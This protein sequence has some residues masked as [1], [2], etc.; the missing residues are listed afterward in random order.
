[1]MCKNIPATSAG[2]LRALLLPAFILMVCSACEFNIDTL[3]VE[4]CT[5]RN[6]ATGVNAGI[7]IEIKFSGEVNRSD[8]EELFVLQ[9][10]DEQITGRFRWSSDKKFVFI[11]SKE[12]DKNGRYTI[13]VPREIRDKDGNTMGS[14]FLSDFYVG[15]DFVNPS[16]VSSTPPYSAG[17]TLDVAIDQDIIINFSKSMNREKTQDAF[18]ISPE[19]SGYFAWGEAAPGLADSRL[20][21][22]LTRNMEYGKLYKLKITGDAEDTAGNRLG[23]DYVVNFVTGDDTTPPEIL[24]IIYVDGDAATSDQLDPSTVK[25]GVSKNGPIT[26]RFNNIIDTT[27]MDRQSVEKSITI[28]P[29]VTGYFDWHSDF[30]VDFRPA[31]SFGPE[32]LYQLAVETSCKDIN[33][34]HLASRY[35]VE[36][37]TDADDSLLVKVGQVSGCN[38]NSAYAPLGAAWPADIEMGDA[39]NDS[40]Y[41]RI[42]FMSS[43]AD[44]TPAVMQKY[45]IFDKVIIETLQS[46]ND[47]TTALHSSAFIGD[48]SWIDDST[49]VIQVSG[50]TNDAADIPALYRLTVTGGKTGIK[51]TNGNYMTEDYVVEFKEVP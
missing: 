2:K 39:A 41:I 21:Y 33:G 18:S 14:D 34:L 48:I 12:L 30:E 13:T 10:T 45:S 31:E 49:V 44:S 36:F 23:T 16:V 37:M 43:I 27:A 1:M 25:H 4:S 29:S 50:M 17:A 6:G 46:A 26:I 32:T 20:E 5:P 8:A 22:R 28:T 24:E 9:N 15:D 42:Q 47:G 7:T 35:A 19:A 11:P 51:D 3:E 38:D 40:Y